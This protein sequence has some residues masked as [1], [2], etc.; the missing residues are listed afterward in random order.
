MLKKE[1]IWIIAGALLGTVMGTLIGIYFA[2]APIK[3]A[4]IISLSVASGTSLGIILGYKIGKN[5]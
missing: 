5:K 2:D 4:L 3:T 1:L